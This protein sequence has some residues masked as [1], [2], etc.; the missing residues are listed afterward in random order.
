MAILCH[1]NETNSKQMFYKDFQSNSW[2]IYY[3]QS[4]FSHSH[5]NILSNEEQYQ[6][7]SFIQQK[8]PI[9]LSKFTPPLSTLCNHPIV[10]VYIPEEKSNRKN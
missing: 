7:E 3:D 2:Y 6:L 9:D 8:N 10:Y 4:M 5:S 1:S